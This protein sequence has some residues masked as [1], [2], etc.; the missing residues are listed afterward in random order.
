[1]K[2]KKTIAR[3]ILRS[4][5]SVHIAFRDVRSIYATP[6]NM[7]EL[8]SDPMEFIERGSQTCEDSTFQIN[9]DRVEL[10]DVLGL[11]LATVNSDKQIICDF[12]ELFQ[13]MFASTFSEAEMTRNLD[14][15]SFELETVFSDEKSYLL[16]Y[17]LEFSRGLKTSLTI[18]KNIKLRDEVQFEILREILNS[19][20]VEEL[21][22]AAKTVENLSKQIESLESKTMYPLRGHDSDRMV[23]VS[24]Y[25]RINNVCAS[26][27]YKYIRESRLTSAV[28]DENGN[29]LL[30]RDEKPVSWD[31]R[32][33]RKRKRSG[34]GVHY[35]RVSNGSAD[36]VKE[37]ILK[38]K[39][40]TNAVAPFI[41]TFEELDYYAKRSY[42]EVI[43]DGR[44]ALIIDVNPD[45]ISQKTGKR[46]RDLM[47]EGKAPVVPDRAKE[48]YV[49][50]IHHV[51]QHWQSP[52]AII[53]EYDHNGKNYSAYFH[54]TKAK[55]DLHGPEF[56][57]AK[58]TF[59]RCYIEKY[60]EAKSFR[61]IP[62]LNSKHNRNK[63]DS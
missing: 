44:P 28:K 18:K 52:F 7:M 10:N 29:F 51:G 12:P 23:S 20:F 2:D 57:A 49:F 60:D 59:W 21:P 48:E 62:Y 56:E 61:A 54:P 33:G 15:S 35:K 16:R 14:M 8:F 11:T 9:R 24:D 13:F 38:Q 3:V 6:K 25:A 58:K 1:M 17:Y 47:K 31:R 40:F 30:K 4:D 27:V 32:K 26:T 50:H 43:W 22:N 46:N 42:H 19:F 53:P 34:D 5:G 39:L 41:H 36:D 45:Y 63:Q 37:H 55:E